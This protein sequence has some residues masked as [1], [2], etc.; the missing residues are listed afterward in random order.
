M[1]LGLPA[2]KES[3]NVI[4]HTGV[5]PS[6]F[7]GQ[8]FGHKSGT[9]SCHFEI[10]LQAF[11]NNECGHPR[12]FDSLCVSTSDGWLDHKNKLGAKSTFKL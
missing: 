7:R 3:C 11:V 5:C 4:T 10:M 9:L 6:L 2:D 1:S 8:Q 12:F